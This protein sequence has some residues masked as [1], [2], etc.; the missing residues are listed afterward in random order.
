VAASAFATRT[1][2]LHVT[3]PFETESGVVLPE[4][5]L[6]Y[7]TYGRLD[8]E[9]RNAIVACHALSG[10]AHAAGVSE[11]ASASAVDGFGAGGRGR[12]GVGWWDGMIGPGKA[13]DTD[14]YFVVCVNALGSCRGSTG[15]R[16]IDPRAGRRYDMTFPVVTVGDMVRAQKL[17]LDHLG[18]R[19]VLATSGGSLGGMQAIEW[20]VRYPEMVV[21]CIPIASTARLAPMGLAWQAIARSAIMA[22][23]KWRGGLYEDDDAPAAGLATARMLGHVTYLSATSIAEKFGRSLQDRD[24]YSYGFGNDFAVESYLRYQGETFTRRFDANSYLYLSR[25]LTYF[26]V[27]PAAL[28]RS[29]AR[30]LILAFS[31]DWL[32]PPTDSAALHAAIPGSEL[33]VIESTYGHDAFLLEEARQTELIRPFL[34]AV[35]A[36]G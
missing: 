18:V 22:D 10:D 17:V 19:R 36:R 27:P 3:E 5:T 24:A 25:A 26:D 4:I 33:H 9:R 28:A 13:F 15:P 14:R 21:A 2:D 7:E 12:G 1:D 8:G 31:S 35:Y 30:W 34:E 20:A 6:A 11:D 23:P 29:R 16:S 32:Y